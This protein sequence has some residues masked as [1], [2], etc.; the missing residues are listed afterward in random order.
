MSIIGAILRLTRIEH[1]VMLCIAVVSAEMLS[2]GLPS[3]EILV[4]SLLTP[5]FISMSAFAINDYFDVEVDRANK[6]MRPLVTGELSMNTALYVTVVSMF[7]GLVASLFIN[8]YAFSIAVLF[9][10]ASLLYGYRLKEMLFWGNAYIAFSMAIPFIF[11]NFV[12]SRSLAPAIIPVSTMI[13]LSGLSREIHGTIR[14]L[15]GD[16]KARDVHTLPKVIGRSTSSV[17]ALLLYAIAIAISAYLFISVVPFERNVTYAFPILLVDVML[18]YVGIGYVYRKTQRF[19]SMARNVSL[20]AM[21][22]ALITILAAAAV[23]VGV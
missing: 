8:T 18:A 7:V 13:F 19:Y 11:G 1:S 22:L 2:G 23:H 15:K 12:V 4:L 14:D 9:G 3:P 16:L 21:A 20:F 17:V 10:A 5:I 6:K